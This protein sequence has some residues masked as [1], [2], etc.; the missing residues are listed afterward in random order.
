MAQG[1][2]ASTDVKTNRGLKA[3][4]A[5]KSVST[6]AVGKAPSK[7]R[8]SASVSL[9]KGR[10]LTG[11]K[12]K[13]KGIN[14][15]ARA[16]ARLKASNQATPLSESLTS[17][18]TALPEGRGRIGRALKAGVAGAGLGALLSESVAKARAGR[19]K[20]AKEDLSFAKDRL[21]SAALDVED[22]TERLKKR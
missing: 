6:A 19:K 7:K 4:K 17:I 10:R 12:K 5:S 8:L 11:R 9:V 13:K 21:G 18:A 14:P 22:A 16:S 3:S 20:R 15:A 2:Y 1:N